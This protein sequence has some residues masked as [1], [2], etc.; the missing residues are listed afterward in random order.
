MCKDRCCL[1]I[2]GYNE[3]SKPQCLIHRDELAALAETAKRV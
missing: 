3:R 1:G 2:K